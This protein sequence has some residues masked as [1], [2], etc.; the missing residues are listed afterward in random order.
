VQV[1]FGVGAQSALA[2]TTAPVL[3]ATAYVLA[4]IP[5]EVVPINS[6]TDAV[7]TPI[8]DP[9]VDYGIAITPDGKTL[10]VSN[11]NSNF[12]SGETPGTV[13][14][15]DIAT[16]TAEAA[17]P[18]GGDEPDTVANGRYALRSRRRQRRPY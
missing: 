11:Y 9:G 4:S 15:I 3:P 6:A 8:L 2:G 18:T 17:I 16:G 5:D 7:G 14:P 10:Y 13:T 12:F 1:L